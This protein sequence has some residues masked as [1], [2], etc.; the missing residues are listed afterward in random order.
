MTTATDVLTGL[1]QEQRE[2][3]FAGQ[4]RKKDPKPPEAGKLTFNLRRGS[5][6]YQIDKDSEITANVRVGKGDNGKLSIKR[7]GLFYR[8]RF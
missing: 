5:V 2:T 6:K 4:A 1:L 3:D 8:K 7:A